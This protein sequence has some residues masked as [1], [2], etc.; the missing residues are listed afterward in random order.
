MYFPKLIM[1]GIPKDIY[2]VIYDFF[3]TVTLMRF[4]SS[5]KVEHWDRKHPYSKYV[6]ELTLEKKK[7]LKLRWTYHFNS[8]DFYNPTSSLYKK[9]VEN[10]RCLENKGFSFDKTS[11]NW[12]VEKCSKKA[13]ILIPGKFGDVYVQYWRH[14]TKS[15]YSGCHI[16]IYTVLGKI[17]R[18]NI[19][20]VMNMSIFKI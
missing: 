19:M 3:D 6:R 1:Y 9:I 5:H 18:L 14:K 17:K 4:I 12:Y 2:S 15:K 11:L 20:H 10:I 8:P 7:V 16:L 13:D